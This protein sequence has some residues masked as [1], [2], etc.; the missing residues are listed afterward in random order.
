MSPFQSVIF[1]QSPADLKFA[2]EIYERRKSAG[3]VLFVTF[4]VDGMRRFL[5]FLQLPNVVVRHISYPVDTPSLR[6]WGGN[7]ALRKWL[8]DILDEHFLPIQGAEVFYF[9]NEIEWVAPACLAYLSRRNHVSWCS[10]HKYSCVPTTAF[11]RH[12]LLVRIYRWISGAEFEW[13]QVEGSPAHKHIL[14]FR[15]DRHGIAHR[16]LTADTSTVLRTYA[17]RLPLPVGQ[18]NALIFENPEE[19]I[20]DDYEA[21][22]RQVFQMLVVAGYTVLI[23]PH[24]RVGHSPFVAAC[25]VQMIPAFIPGEFLPMD[26]FALVLGFTSSALGY[27]AR[28]NTERVFS[29]AKLLHARDRQLMDYGVNYVAKV[30]E[31]RLR[32]VESLSELQGIIQQRKGMAA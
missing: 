31:G 15:S 6:R 7:W 24:P 8:R 4:E 5:E 11:W 21:V 16:P 25:P 14:W 2:L 32:F 28:E 10:H 19:N 13:R 30:A 29:L 12:H 9:S 26:Q 3:A 23:K 20:A 27:V 17:H 1:C 22:L 18:R